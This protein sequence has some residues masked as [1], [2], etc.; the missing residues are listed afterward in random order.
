MTSATLNGSQASTLKAAG[1]MGGNRG[2]WVAGGT[3]YI[4]RD[5][6]LAGD[7]RDGRRYTGGFIGSLKAIRVVCSRGCNGDAPV[8][9]RAAQRGI[10]PA[11]TSR[12]IDVLISATLHV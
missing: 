10:I 2:E 4:D 1:S 3:S 11:I 9:S 8:H 7:Y 12:S 5:T 6:V